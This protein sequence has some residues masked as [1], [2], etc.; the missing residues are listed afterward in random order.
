MFFF[1]NSIAIHHPTDI[2]KVSAPEN[3][4][5]HRKQKTKKRS[6][7]TQHMLCRFR[8]HTD[9]EICLSYLRIIYLKIYYNQQHFISMIK[10]YLF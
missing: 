1:A 4:T 7:P 3:N 8:Y 6:L 5:Q 2:D 9:K 10:L